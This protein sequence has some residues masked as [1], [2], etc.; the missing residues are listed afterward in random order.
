[1]TLFLDHPEWYI[2]GPLF[3]IT[4][5]A[6]YAVSNKPL[7]A[8]GFYAQLTDMILGRPMKEAWRLWY[9]L[10][11]MLGGSVAAWI[12]GDL[13]PV[14]YYGKMGEL[15]PI[16]ALIPILFIGGLLMGI[17]ARFAGGCRLIFISSWLHPSSYR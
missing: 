4:V 3:G 8:T 2:L 9:L 7:G 1:M 5:A 14:S 6:M 15:L 13:G 11:V 10:G 16:Q 12:G 17:G